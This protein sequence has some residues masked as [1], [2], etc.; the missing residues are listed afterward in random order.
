MRITIV[1]GAF[2]PVPA[3]MGGAVEKVWHALGKEF[4]RRGHQVTHVSRQYLE[5]PVR[6]VADGVQHVR[7][8]GFDAPASL[9][10]LKALDFIYSLRVL[11]R[12][13]AADILVTNTFW[14]PVL[15]RDPNL[16]ETYVH[17]A[18]YPRGQMRFYS[19]VARLQTVTRSVADAIKREAPRLRSRV[20]VIPYP[21]IENGTGEPSGD[22]AG[23]KAKRILFVGRVHP[24]KGL[25]LLIQAFAII[26]RE[27]LAGW[28][29]VIVGPAETRHGGGGETYLKHL[30]TIAAPIAD[31]VDW[32]GAVFDPGQLADFYRQASI[33]VYPSL[34]EFGE[35]FGLAPLEAMSNGCPPLVSDLHCFRDYLQDGVNGYVFDHRA[36][37]PAECL[38]RRI[39]EC[40]GD[41]QGLKRTAQ[42]ALL[43]AQDYT[44]QSVGDAF[45]RDFE[46]VLHENAAHHPRRG[47]S[48]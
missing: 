45:L 38:A 23:S 17:V 24:E 41:L 32:V 30:K 7:V 37:D 8:P 47:K 10:R 6:E 40:I 15:V 48:N 29:L 20:R 1:Q 11:W 39:E 16:G 2:F 46:S 14:L 9:L 43:T 42:R 22:C 33:F 19:R 12:L 31:R 4:S 36:S 44:V 25:A 13:P 21:T 35:T 5:M 3:V 18:R 34:A 28:R 26:P 27:R